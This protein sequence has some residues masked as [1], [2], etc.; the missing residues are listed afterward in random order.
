MFYIGSATH[1]GTFV[2]TFAFTD[3]AGN[4]VVPNIVSWT[5]FDRSSAVMNGRSGVSV[6]PA[7]TVNIT[8]SDADLDADEGVDEW[9]VFFVEYEYDSTEG[10]DLPMNGAA[11]FKIVKEH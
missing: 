6:T 2:V 8:L 1:E 7:A 3:A 10:T 5:L 9:R 4:S 11:L